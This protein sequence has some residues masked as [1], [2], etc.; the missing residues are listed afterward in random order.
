MFCCLEYRWKACSTDQQVLR[1][2]DFIAR[3]NQLRKM[4]TSIE[5]HFGFSFKKLK[6]KS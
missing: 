6:I 2:S 4:I 3:S 1:S 5:T